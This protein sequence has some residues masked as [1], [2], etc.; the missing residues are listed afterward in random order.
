MK[1]SCLFAGLA[2]ATALSVSDAHALLATSQGI[3]FDGSV[4]TSCSFSGEQDGKLGVATNNLSLD[5]TLTEGSSGGVTVIANDAV[6]VTFSQPTFTANSGSVAGATTQVSVQGGAFETG[7]KTIDVTPGS[8]ALSV[9]V[10]AEKSTAFT[11]GSYTLTTIAT[12]AAA[13]IAGGGGDEGD[14]D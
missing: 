7:A 10:R 11:A 8:T 5:S 3:D 14:D 9:D 6:E 1:H 4:A 2:A 13:Q 12:C